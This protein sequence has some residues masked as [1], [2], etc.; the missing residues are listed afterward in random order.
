[1]PASTI[2]SAHARR[3]IG[4]QVIV[5]SP[6]SIESQ[7]LSCSGSPVPALQEPTFVNAVAGVISET[8]RA[9]LIDRHTRNLCAVKLSLGHPCIE[10]VDCGE[11]PDATFIDCLDPAQQIA[12]LVD[13]RGLHFKPEN[14]PRKY[15]QRAG[16][17]PGS[18]RVPH[19]GKSPGGRSAVAEP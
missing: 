4:L 5:I 14:S 11:D 12:F 15:E 7:F 19:K 13:V 10:M 9:I 8:A 3:A 17:V 2:G 1:M 18:S 6:L 16:F